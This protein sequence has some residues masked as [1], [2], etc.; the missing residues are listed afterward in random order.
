MLSRVT[1]EADVVEM[2]HDVWTRDDEHRLE[3]LQK[4]QVTTVL[5]SEEELELSDLVSK[6]EIFY[7]AGMKA[8]RE[9]RPEYGDPDDDTEEQAFSKRAPCCLA[10]SVIFLLIVAAVLIALFVS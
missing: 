1:D 4:K 7:E 5:T 2:E 6:R 10:S 9:A 3:E 8:L